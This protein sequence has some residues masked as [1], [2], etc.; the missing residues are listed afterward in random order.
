MKITIVNLLTFLLASNYCLGM[1]NNS[2]SSQAT[3][4]SSTPTKS[5][6]KQLKKE[7][8][9]HFERI[10]PI[11]TAGAA[12]YIYSS[13]VDT[14]THPHSILLRQPKGTSQPQEYEL[15]G[16]HF[17]ISDITPNLCATRIAK[18]S[19]IKA[20]EFGFTNGSTIEHTCNNGNDVYD[21]TVCLG[22]ATSKYSGTPSSDAYNFR[23]AK[24]NSLTANQFLIRN[25][26]HMNHINC[27]FDK[28]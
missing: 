25:K 21:V 16:S 20:P 24:Q 4:Q 15:L 17:L 12:L 13:I 28:I 3:H 9:A 18:E 10:N 11:K 6:S 2:C 1:D 14:T 5:E 27:A 8:K 26:D 19:G 23:W 7:L 22:F